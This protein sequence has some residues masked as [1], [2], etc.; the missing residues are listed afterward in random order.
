VN[1]VYYFL[2]FTV[3]VAGLLVA[4]S[5][6]PGANEA[7]Q[8]QEP[9]SRAETL[10]LVKDDLARR[11]TIDV[12][13]IEVAAES[14][15]TWSDSMLGCSARKPLEEPIST[16]GFAFTLSHRGRSYVY[17]TDRRGHFRRCD[18]AKPVAPV[19]R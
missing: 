1:Q 2:V 8:G 3:V 4:S 14:D 19:V 7:F 12:T 11:L 10:K 5:L 18:T 9:L 6:M 13:E 15:E 16:P 17:H